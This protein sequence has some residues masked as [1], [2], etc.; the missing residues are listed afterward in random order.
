MFFVFFDKE[1]AD[2]ASCELKHVSQYHITLKYCVGRGVLFV[3]E[4]E[5]QKGM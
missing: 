3:Y 4:I 2:E 1:V 5:K